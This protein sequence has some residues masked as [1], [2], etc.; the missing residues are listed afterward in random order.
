MESIKFVCPNCF[1]T[2]DVED[3]CY[4]CNS[5]GISQELIFIEKFL[6]EHTVEYLKY[7]LHDL[8]IHTDWKEKRRK[9]IT[10]RLLYLIRLKEERNVKE[11][12]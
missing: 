9:T 8:L 2:Y 1:K 6:E 10:D 11:N 4:E 3:I 5:E 12:N 7:L